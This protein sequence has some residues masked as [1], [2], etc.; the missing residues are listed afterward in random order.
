M[1]RQVWKDHVIQATASPGTGGSPSRSLMTL[2]R[3]LSLLYEGTVRYRNRLYDGKILHPVRLPRPVV[4]VGNLTTGGTGKTPMILH[5]ARFYQDRGYRPAVISRGYGSRGA[6]RVNVV[7]DGKAVLLDPDRAGDE[8][9]LMARFLGNVPVVTGAKRVE[10]GYEALKRFRP[11]I[12]LLDDGFQH[13]K[14]GRD[15]DIL[16]MD[17]KSPFG[18]GHLL[19]RGI[20]REPPESLSRADAI[21]L[22]GAGETGGAP[23]ATDPR[24]PGEKPL[25][26]AHRKGESFIRG[27]ENIRRPLADFRGKPLVAFSGIAAPRSFHR[28]L[29][30]ISG[31]APACI[32]FP[33]HHRYTRQDVDRLRRV[34]GRV[35]G[36]VL[37]T[38]EKD[39]VRLEKFPDF[40]EECHRLRIVMTLD[41]G[42]EAF[43]DLLLGVL[44]S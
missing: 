5:L 28:M 35:P 29:T 43:E 44:S 37:V 21:I 22:T 16:L 26:R 7:S 39:G 12:L 24:I 9:Y 15:L 33:D 8:P 11:D 40:H 42:N 32:M 41:D 34:A 23:V 2:L 27:R 30:Q 10:A 19:P 25:F 14:I 36:A 3:G 1:R 6:N 17:E 31:S 13:R 18:N 38:T 4:C 20:L